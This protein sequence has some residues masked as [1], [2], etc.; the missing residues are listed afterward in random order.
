VKSSFEKIHGVTHDGI[1]RGLSRLSEEGYLYGVGLLFKSYVEHCSVCTSARGKP[2]VTPLRPILTEYPNHRWV[3]DLTDMPTDPV[4]GH[5]NMW[6]CIDHFS[7]FVWTRPLYGKNAALT[8]EALSAVVAENGKPTVL[9]MDNGTEFLDELCRKVY[10]ELGIQ[11]VRG[12]PEH[13][14]TQGKCER[15]HQSVAA[16]CKRH[17]AL[18][19]GRWVEALEKVTSDF[20]NSASS[21]LAGKTPFFVYHG[22]WPTR[23]REGVLTVVRETTP[24]VLSPE[25]RRQVI[26]EVQ[27]AMIKHGVA[28]VARQ[29]KTRRVVVAPL[30]VGTFVKVRSPPDHR[31]GLLWRVRGVVVRT[32]ATR[33][34]YDVQLTTDGYAPSQTA[35]CVLENVDF[36]RVM[37]VA[38]SYDTAVTHHLVE[39]NF[40]ESSND[41]ALAAVTYKVEAVVARR[42]AAGQQLYLTK[43]CHYPWTQCTWQALDTFTPDVQTVLLER[44]TVLPTVNKTGKSLENYLAKLEGTRTVVSDNLLSK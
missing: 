8:C 31:D 30:P 20:N 41:L 39:D 35:G 10:L 37:F 17:A 16:A 2:T 7:S 5:K 4:T 36:T 24:P 25:S 14:Q 9:G 13:P 38:D 19:Q 3:C 26:T 18:N 29:A 42:V 44:R 43:W 27:A 32:D 23:I 1:A 11:V 21:A 33:Y 6:V 28:N 40:G 15:V 12:R 22:R 34:M